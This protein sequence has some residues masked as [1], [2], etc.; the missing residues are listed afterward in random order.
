LKVDRTN[1]ADTTAARR[2]SCGYRIQLT[3]ASCVNCKRR[4][5]E[6]APYHDAAGSSNPPY[7][8]DAYCDYNGFSVNLDRG[9]CNFFDHIGKYKS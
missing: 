4:G 9:I 8:C 1:K 2:K 7:H 5:A 6:S 3:C